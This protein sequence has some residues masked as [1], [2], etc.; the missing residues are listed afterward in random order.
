MDTAYAEEGRERS[1]IDRKAD[2]VHALRIWII[3]LLGAIFLVF[4]AIHAT[5]LTELAEI[6]NK[7]AWGLALGFLGLLVGFIAAFMATSA[8]RQ[9]RDNLDKLEDTALIVGDCTCDFEKLYSDFLLKPLSDAETRQVRARL[10]LSTPAF[11]YPVL[12]A[13]R[14]AAFRST[15]DHL[16]KG[17]TV[18]LILFSPDAHFFHWANTLLG[19]TTAMKMRKSEGTRVGHR[20]S[21]RAFATC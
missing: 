14:T 11:G 9:A 5:R 12:G 18:E 21:P 2:G 20:G 17:S 16:K 13:K 4:L 7:E 1:E 8:E 15:L 3:L 19:L 6:K 10:L